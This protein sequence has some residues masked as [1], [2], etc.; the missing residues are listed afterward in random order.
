MR[1]HRQPKPLVIG[2]FTGQTR[3]LEE[4][5]LP[6]D[7]LDPLELWCAR[8]CAAIAALAACIFVTSSSFS[9]R[10][11]RMLVRRPR[12]FSLAA[13]RAFSRT[14]R[15]SRAARCFSVSEART[16]VASATSRFVA[17][18]MRRASRIWLDNVFRWS[19]SCL[20]ASPIVRK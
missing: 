2:P 16:A 8:I 15:A 20:S 5:P 9:C 10:W 6:L 11:E 1:P 14:T 12:W 18:V 3:P 7:P 4:E 13:A 17:A 19:A